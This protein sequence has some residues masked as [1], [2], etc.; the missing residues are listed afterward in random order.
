[1]KYVRLAV[2]LTDTGR[3]FLWFITQTG[4]EWHESGDS[5]ILTAMTQWVKV[6]S[7][8]SG[9]RQDPPEVQQPEPVFPDAPFAEYL[10]RAFK[11]RYID[12]LDHP[13]IKRL[14]GIR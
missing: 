2:A 11:D 6:V 9:Y 10:R 3:L 7:D 13:V 14:A 8:G 4:S 5:A 12:N 1:M